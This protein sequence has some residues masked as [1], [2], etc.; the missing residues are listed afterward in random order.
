M[1]YNK[2]RS[3]DLLNDVRVT[4]T[5]YDVT[6]STSSPAR[7]NE[8]GCMIVPPDRLPWNNPHQI[9]TREVSS[10]VNTIPSL[11]SFHIIII[12]CDIP[13]APTPTP[14]SLLPKR[15]NL[16]ACDLILLLLILYLSPFNSLSLCLSVSSLCLSHFNSISLCLSVPVSVCL[17]VCL[18]VSLSLFRMLSPSLSLPLLFSSLARTSC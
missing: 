6:N 8:E 16:D 11:C 2:S 12:N 10:L 4:T 14:R 1:F 18:S 15:V 7:F 5:D 13:P 9:I 17:S 3:A